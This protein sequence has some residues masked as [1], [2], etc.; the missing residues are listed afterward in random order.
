M[1]QGRNDDKAGAP[2][3]HKMVEKKIRPDMLSFLKE[4]LDSTI[5]LLN[6]DVGLPGDARHLQV[7]VLVSSTI[8]A[9]FLRTVS[10]LSPVTADMESQ[11]AGRSRG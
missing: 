2:R 1:Q 9:S 11:S 6:I 10:T 7:A 5:V 8:A 3:Y 4:R